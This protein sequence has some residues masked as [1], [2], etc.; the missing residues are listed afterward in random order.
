MKILFLGLCLVSFLF[1]EVYY[2]K[3]EPYEIRTISSNVSGLV[4]EADENLLGKTLGAK[5]YITIDSD[6]DEKE[7]VAV[8]KKL[9]HLK[10]TLVAN[11]SIVN[12]LELSLVKKRE[13]YKKVSELAIK[14]TIEKDKEFYDLVT[15][16]NQLL[17]TQKEIESLKIQVADLE[18]RQANL[19][20]SIADKH[21]VANGFVLYTLEVKPGQVVSMATPLAKIA[22]VSKAKLTLFLDPS[23]V[24]DAQK[25]VVYIDGVKSEYKVSR[26]LHI[27]DSKNISKYMAQIIMQ[28]PKLFSNL[29]KV[30]LR[31]E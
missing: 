2:A 21:L 15:S 19:E 12:N 18:L 7:L 4:L 17:S 3:V 8:A 5:A 27:A 14:S 23:D 20:R 1:G 16:E 29:V 6:L 11:E 30:E 13:N 31:D 28:A 24:V 9:Q 10:A 25:K 26:V 22:D